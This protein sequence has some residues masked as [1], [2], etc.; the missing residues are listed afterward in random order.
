MAI[1]HKW[2]MMMVGECYFLFRSGLGPKQ[3]QQHSSKHGDHMKNL[4]CNKAS[5]E[6]VKQTNKQTKPIIF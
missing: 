3:G 2:M 1:T 6:N 4:H 5:L